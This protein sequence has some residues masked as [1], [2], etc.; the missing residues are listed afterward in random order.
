MLLNA[1]QIAQL[2]EKEGMIEPFV[3]QKIQ[4]AHIPSYGL[5]PYGYTFRIANKIYYSAPQL[6]LGGAT[7]LKLDGIT[8]GWLEY[9]EGTKI[10]IPPLALFLCSSLEYFRL[11]PNITGLLVGKSTYTRQGICY[12]MTVVDAGFHGNITFGLVNLSG[13]EIEITLGGGIGQILF[14]EGE[15]NLNNYAYTGI[16]QGSQ[17]IA[18]PLLH[19]G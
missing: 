9:P 14:I 18:S 5:E 12:L 16:W 19:K 6:A 1:E 7:A 15:P 2:A 11:P 13:R 8:E 3:N 4:L 17:G 10:K